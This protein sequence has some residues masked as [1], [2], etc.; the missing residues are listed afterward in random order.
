MNMGNMDL[1]SF[2]N[3]SDEQRQVVVDYLHPIHVEL[4]ANLTDENVTL[5]IGLEYVLQGLGAEGY[6]FS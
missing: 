4:E 3:M 6:E 1:N 2:V 5:T